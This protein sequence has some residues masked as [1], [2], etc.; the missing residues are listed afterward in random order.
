MHP[1]EYDRRFFSIWNIFQTTQYKIWIHSN[2]CIKSAFVAI[3]FTN[4]LQIVVKSDIA[5]NVLNI[6]IELL[7]FNHAG[8]S[9][10]GM[11]I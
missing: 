6:E 2:L 9:C 3:S 7:M 5:S 4:N 10:K 8:N 1:E 11:Y